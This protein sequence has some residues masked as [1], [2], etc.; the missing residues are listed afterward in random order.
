MALSHARTPVVVLPCPPA[1]AGPYVQP[2]NRDEQR[3]GSLPPVMTDFRKA[4]QSQ[5]RIRPCT[6]ALP[7]LPP[8]PH[9]FCA[10][11]AA[12]DGSTSTSD[13]GT[14]GA[15]LFTVAPT[16]DGTCGTAPSP[17]D[18]QQRS[19]LGC[20]PASVEEAYAAAGATPY[21]H[22]L[23]ELLGVDYSQLLP[24][25]DAAPQCERAEQQQQQ[26]QQQRHDPRSA[27]PLDA[28]QDSAMARL[29][30]ARVQTAC[31]QIRTI[32][33]IAFCCPGIAHP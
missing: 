9:P 22:A 31:T 5:S 17:P 30:C 4:V 10:A 27:F 20:I 18:Q 33:C 15:A 7:A 26:Q 23:Q 13:P 21:L 6:G 16:L 14:S 8:L 29:R 32:F 11:A 2:P 12:G 25:P 3:Y 19:L 1:L 24:Q 28:G